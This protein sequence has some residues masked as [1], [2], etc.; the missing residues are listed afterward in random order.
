[1]KYLRGAIETQG[2]HVE[3]RKLD[4]T[5]LARAARALLLAVVAGQLAGCTVFTDM[6]GGSRAVPMNPGV[7]L[8]LLIEDP[9]YSAAPLVPVVRS[10]WAGS[11]A[12]GSW[13][14]LVDRMIDPATTVVLDIDF[15]GVTRESTRVGN[16]KHGF[17]TIYSTR[18]EVVFTLTDVRSGIIVA[19]AT[20]SSSSSGSSPGG[21]VDQRAV[22]GAVQ[23]GLRRLMQVYA[24]GRA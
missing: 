12:Y 2:S 13:F 17:S 14:V 5:P 10:A 6:S 20:G 7:R 19:S 21:Q 11:D 9:D 4:G 1:M 15:R 16:A 23:N 22:S 3:S 24:G 8:D 18:A